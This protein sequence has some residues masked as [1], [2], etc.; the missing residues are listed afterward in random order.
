M[1]QLYLK[2]LLTLLFILLAISLFAQPENDRCDNAILLDIAIDANSCIPIIGDTRETED[3]SMV[4]GPD[5]C[6]AS[7]YTD[8]VWYKVQVGD[9]V[10]VSGITIEV[11]LDPNIPTDIKEQNGMAVYMN[12]DVDTEPLDCF[13]DAPGRS[14]IQIYPNCIE[15]N[16]EFYIRV[17][18]GM[19]ATGNA[20]T[21]AFYA[22]ISAE[23][24]E[25]IGKPRI[26]YEENFN[27][28]LNGWT[29]NA[30]TESLDNN[31]GILKPDDW[32]WTPNNC[33]PNFSGN[34]ECLEPLGSVCDPK[35]AVAFP[36][37][38]Y[39]TGRTGDV[40]QI[41]GQPF[42]I[43]HAYLVSPSI[44]LSDET[45]VRLRWTESMRG[46]F[47]SDESAF[48]SLV[49]FSIDGGMTWRFPSAAVGSGDVS[50]NYGGNYEVNVSQNAIEREIPLLGAEGQ[51][52]VRIR[53]GFKGD[54][55]FWI[56]DDVQ[57]IQPNDS[58]FSI[59]ENSIST[60]IINPMS[61]HQIDTVNFMMD[62]VNLSAINYEDITVEI[63][64]KNKNQELVF[65]ESFNIG[66]LPSDSIQKEIIFPF[67]FI[68]QAE[69]DDYTFV[70]SVEFEVDGVIDATKDSFDLNVVD[71]Q[72]FRK[73]FGDV[74]GSFSPFDTNNAV[75]PPSDLSW[76]IGNIFYC[77]NDT[78]ETFSPFL[79]KEVSFALANP[80]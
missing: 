52:D 48:G 8:D 36:S 58:G 75:A 16:S 43:N 63:T 6:S 25:E 80:E 73:E 38:W 66:N 23:E 31:E 54:F 17:W 62:L 77:T 74:T 29:N 67:E 20:G 10:P 71:E 15:S 53:F 41:T 18:S 13:S 61:I 4:E 56:I 24:E 44:D 49:E 14:E 64:G 51:P 39:Q 45:Y 60:S 32:V 50:T 76:E 21:F 55:Y 57:I 72:I 46:L 22:Y 78:Y 1:N 70:Y 47:G 7:W 65:E 5:V 2:H 12:C 68:P 9:D 28:G 19:S 37:G 27:A 34:Q 33:I 35:G 40:S 79:F 59:P 69:V 30:I 11:R 3:A 26:I 42:E